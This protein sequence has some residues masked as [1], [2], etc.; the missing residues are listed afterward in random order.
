MAK[1][2]RRVR[3]EER[4]LRRMEFAH[5]NKALFDKERQM[6]ELRSA[7]IQADQMENCLGSLSSAY[8]VA[9]GQRR[10]IEEL[11][12]RAFRP[13]QPNLPPTVRARRSGT[14]RRAIRASEG[15][16]GARK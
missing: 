1:L 14:S 9:A 16:W 10:R 5:K 13:G 3:E 6:R 15:R 8:R 2:E 4:R 12:K 7:R 11:A